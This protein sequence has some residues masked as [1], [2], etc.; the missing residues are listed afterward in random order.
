MEMPDQ[1]LLISVGIHLCLVILT[2]SCIRHAHYVEAVTAALCTAA[3]MYNL[4][5]W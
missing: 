4:K 5:L 2:V 3:E 1:K